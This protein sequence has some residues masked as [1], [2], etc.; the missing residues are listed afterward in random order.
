[1]TEVN[2]SRPS[3]N[4]INPLGAADEVIDNGLSNPLKTTIPMQ[5]VS[6]V[7]EEPIPAT[8]H[9]LPSDDRSTAAAASAASEGGQRAVESMPG[10][11]SSTKATIEGPGHE[12]DVRGL[13]GT[14]LASVEGQRGT[15][16]TMN[17]T[18]S[19][20]DAI[21]QTQS[22]G[23]PSMTTT[24]AGEL[25]TGISSLL[26]AECRLKKNKSQNRR[27]LLRVNL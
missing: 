8:A 19:S 18:Q 24:I 2:H 6:A 7:R 3:L 1:M 20:N 5:E 15:E 14:G 26:N 4:G 23:E 13:N 21:A 11:E 16:V 22:M 27:R 17:S 12:S 25:C 9:Y 10:G